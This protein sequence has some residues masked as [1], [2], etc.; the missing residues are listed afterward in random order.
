MP[1]SP[2]SVLEWQLAFGIIY[3]ENKEI[4][5]PL[6]WV[7]NCLFL[8]Y[9]FV[10]VNSRHPSALVYTGPFIVQQKAYDFSNYWKI[11]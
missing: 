9:K 2:P 8:Q 1:V 4:I 11:L 5:L 3:F 10:M 6:L 7:I